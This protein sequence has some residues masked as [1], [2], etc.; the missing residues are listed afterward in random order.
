MRIQKFLA[1]IFASAVLV[2]SP[3]AIDA[4]HD[5]SFSSGSC[6][7]CHKLHAST[8]GTLTGYNSNNDAC[9][10]C[11]DTSKTLGAA[12]QL[13]LPWSVT[14]DQAIPGVSGNHHNWQGAATAPQFGA[15]PPSNP[16]MLSRLVSGT[17]QCA[18]CHDPHADDP[19]FAP[20]SAHAS[21]PLGVAIDKTDG[22]GSGQL[23]LVSMGASPTGSGYRLQISSPG[24]FMYSRDFGKTIPTWTGPFSYTL[25][26]QF[27]IDSLTLVLSGAPAAGDFWD[28]YVGYPRLRQTNVDDA[29]CVQCHASR[30]MS[31]SVVGADSTDGTTVLSHPVG[32][33]VALG[34]NGGGYD[35]TPATMLDATGVAQSVGVG[36]GNK[37][38]DLVFGSGNTMRCTTCHAPHGADSNSLTVDLR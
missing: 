3:Q 32:T 20:N 12:N 38:N 33:G 26:T 5:G 14:N 11:H 18:T 22:T 37:T 28:F 34:A 21:L 13:G 7:S 17:I 19:S 2:G 6:D 9:I 31:H 4:P 10:T 16:D 36:D 8:G 24:Q 30:V 27:G 23:T 1:A 35:L 29:M 15:V 25:G